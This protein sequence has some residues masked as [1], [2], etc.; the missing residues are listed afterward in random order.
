[1]RIKIKILII[2]QM[3]NKNKLFN[4]KMIIIVLL[5][6]IRVKNFLLKIINNKFNIEKE[7]QK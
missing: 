6:M 5:K 1:M 4:L 3:K 7:F 2:I